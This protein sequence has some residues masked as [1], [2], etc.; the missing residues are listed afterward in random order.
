[1]QISSVVRW[2]VTALAAAPFLVACGDPDMDLPADAGKT[3]DA[4]APVVDA[5]VPDGN[6]DADTT[7]PERLELGAVSC[8][9]TATMSFE[10]PNRGQAPLM[11]SFTGLGRDV[12]MQPS[13]GIVAPGSV[14]AITVTARVPA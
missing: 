8:G 3:V 10:L 1:M 7:L 13:E 14:Q 2:S 12:R 5:S 6:V 4:P 11:Y 9:T